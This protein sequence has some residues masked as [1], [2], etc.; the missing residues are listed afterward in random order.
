MITTCTRCECLFDTNSE[1]YANEPDRLCPSCVREDK[2]RNSQVADAKV[3]RLQATR[4]PELVRMRNADNTQR[5]ERR[6][7]TCAHG[8]RLLPGG[9]Q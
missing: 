5:M 6:T 1:E 4:G 2:E 7:H 8:L 9:G 3:P